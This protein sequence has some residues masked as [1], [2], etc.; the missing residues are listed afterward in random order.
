[1]HQFQILEREYVS[2]HILNEVTPLVTAKS[3]HY[4]VCGFTLKHDPDPLNPASLDHV[5]HHRLE[6]SVC[7]KINPMR[8]PELLQHLFISIMTGGQ[9]AVSLEFF[10]DA[11]HEVLFML[12]MK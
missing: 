5:P 8:T 3:F 1:M 7:P 6:M 10:T 12:M 11:N 2:Y 4:H 9:Q